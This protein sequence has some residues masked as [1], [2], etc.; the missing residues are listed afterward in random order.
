[1]TSTLL[2]RLAG[3]MQSWGTQ[4]RFRV[5][6]TGAEPSKSG[7]VGL[8]A[9]ALGRPRSESV[10]DLAGLHLGVRVDK[11]GVMSSDYHTAGGTH[12]RG[13]NYGVALVG[14]G[15]ETAQSTRYYLA[16]ADFLVGLEGEAELLAELVAA[17]DRPHWALC[18]GRRAFVPGEP[19]LLPEPEQGLRSGADLE[20]ALTK[21]PW[22]R[23]DLP[24]SRPEWRPK[25]LRLVL[26][27][28]RGQA[29]DAR[30]DQP[31]GAAFQ[32]RTFA[33]RYTSTTFPALGKQV[34]V[35][36]ESPRAE[37]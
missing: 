22:P 1:M 19:V 34:P 36:G 26:E 17:L 30:H 14:G 5:R 10:A 13:D 37:A 7:V 8:L 25:Q 24:V 27:V 12:L 6:D 18:L 2:L 9:A 15:H 31:V 23:L 29:G 35:R 32:D 33:T 4:S 11:E 16:D 3:P 20:T 21:Y 28:D